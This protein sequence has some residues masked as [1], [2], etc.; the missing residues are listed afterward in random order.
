MDATQKKIKVLP[1]KKTSLLILLIVP[2]AA[3]CLKTQAQKAFIHPGI[4]HTQASLN[5][6]YTVA[7]QKIMHGYGSYELLRD[8]PV[9]SAD[10]TMNGPYDT[11]SRDGKYA[12]TKS[13]MEA[14][15]SAAYL[16]ALMFAATKDARHA[17][18]SIDNKAKEMELRWKA[19]EKVAS[20]KHLQVEEQK[21]E[22]SAALESSAKELDLWPANPKGDVIE[23]RGSQVTY[24]ALGQQ[25][26]AER[27]SVTLRG[28][29]PAGAVEA[30]P[31]TQELDAEGHARTVA[32][33]L[34]VL[35]RYVQRRVGGGGRDVAEERL[36][37]GGLAAHPLDR[38]GE[39]H[40]CRV[41]VE[42]LAIAVA[43]VDVIEVVVV[44]EVG[45]AADV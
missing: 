40:V 5:R 42:L 29:L 24:S 10:Y 32:V 4:L 27:W 23:D 26:A 21:K 19:Q 39:E 7:Q 1:M 11:I 34:D 16:N 22:I 31:S 28:L 15:F 36:A 8:N 35:F 43:R 9:A 38:T 20:K 37:L 33:R 6:M 30:H 12:W 17:K 13:K 41:A 45:S 25:A 14:D 44:P 3:A 18:K 2:L